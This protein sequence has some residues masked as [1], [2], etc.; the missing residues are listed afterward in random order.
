[1]TLLRGPKD[2]DAFRVTVNRTRWYRD[3]LPADGKWSAM[4]EA[5]PAVTTLKGAWS[6]PFKKKTPDGLVVPLDAYRAAAYVQDNLRE[7]AGMH[8]DQVFAMVATAP[9]RDL[10]KAA[11]RGTAVHSVIEAL[12]VGQ[13]LAPELHDD[14][15]R[16]FIPACEQFVDEWQPDWRMTECV[17]INRTLGFAGTADSFAVLP[18]TCAK[19]GEPYGLTVIDYKSRGSGHGAYEEEVC[20]L[21]GYASGEYIVITNAAGGLERID[22]PDVRH[23]AIVSI[24]ADDGYRLYPVEI[25]DAR[26]AF[27]GLFETWRIK[28]DGQ[29]VAR[30]SVGSPAAR[31]NQERNDVYD[32]TAEHVVPQRRAEGTGNPGPTEAGDHPDENPSR[33]GSPSS[34]VAGAQQPPSEPRAEVDAA[35]DEPGGEQQ[36]GHNVVQAVDQAAADGNDRGGDG[37]HLPTAEQETG[38]GGSPPFDLVLGH[39]RSRVAVIKEA[40]MGRPL[41]VLWPNGTP[42]FKAGGVT[43]EHLPAIAEWCDAVEGAWQLPFPPP[44]PG[45]DT[46]PAAP[47]VLEAPREPR[48][49]RRAEAEEWAAKGRALLGLLHDEQLARA[50][51]ETAR[52]DDALM[53]RERFLS[54]QAVVTQMSE[55]AGVLVAHWSSDGVDLRAVRDMEKA[56]LAQMPTE[57]NIT[58]A[59]KLDALRRAKRVAK[60]L[61]MQ[62]PKSY[63]ELCG[64]LLLAACVA[65]GHGVNREQS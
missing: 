10:A 27:L 48:R 65:V 29:R 34:P 21:G 38:E 41:P 42:T 25:D 50:C 63:D 31:P 7:L 55:P 16:P 56:L 58:K 53:T 23:G 26:H 49:D 22:P 37:G 18:G 46:P 5:V 20:Q 4:T 11:N 1:M 39:V 13:R 3:P 14:A 59:T 24:T 9:D 47:P 8:P 6:K 35:V 36:R 57:G 51:A 15:V 60:R 61:G 52:C 17:V 32:Q 40:A 12:A 2:A 45:E 33:H 54:L 30:L 62:S 44:A 28:R 64:D 19:C 43:A